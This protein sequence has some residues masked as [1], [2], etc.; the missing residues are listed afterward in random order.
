MCNFKRMKLFL[1]IFVNNVSQNF[2]L[3]TRYKVTAAF[4]LQLILLLLFYQE[5]WNYRNLWKD[6]F[7]LEYN[8]NI[9]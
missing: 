7:I 8:Q 4:F 3:K 1:E 2:N 9:L 5:E 6:I